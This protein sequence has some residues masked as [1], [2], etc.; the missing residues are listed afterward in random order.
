VAQE[1]VVTTGGVTELST[2]FAAGLCPIA[3]GGLGGTRPAAKA[4]VLKGPNTRPLISR[5]VAPRVRHQDVEKR[6]N[7]S[8]PKVR[9]R[10][11]ITETLQ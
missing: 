7:V 9:D 1:V 5:V 4:A 11:S 2:T 6:V 3:V 10:L 8:L